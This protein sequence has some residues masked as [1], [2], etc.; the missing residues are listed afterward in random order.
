VPF[1]DI[2]L[3]A[4]EVSKEYDLRPVLRNV[5]LDLMRGDVLA[6]TGRN[7]SGKS[8]LIKILA[9]VLERSNGTIAW[10]LEGENLKEERLPVHIGLVG[11]YLTLYMEFSLLEH[12]DL[13][14]SLRGV[15]GDRDYTMHLIEHVGLADRSR[16]L[17]SE[18]SS[19][20]LQRAR[21][22]CAM[23]H[24]PAFLFLDEPGM[25][26]DSAGVAAVADLIRKEQAERI[27]II[28][29][30]DPDDLQLATAELNVERS[31]QS[32]A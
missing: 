12:V 5:D 11:P 25:N 2:Q 6:V 29:T 15:A 28:G 20:M 30:N 23:A 21:F 13:L 9:N 1:R 18:F 7:G 32:T 14:A 31:L 26:L 16:D 22:V 3:S 19:G 24:R 10:S 4:R 17:L 8:T 27:T